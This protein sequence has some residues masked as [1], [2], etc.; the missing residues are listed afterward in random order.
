M[1]PRTACL[2]G[3]LVVLAAGRDAAAAPQVHEITAKG[4][5]AVEVSSVVA[6]VV[7]KKGA[8]GKVRVTAELTGGIMGKAEAEVHFGGGVLSIDGLDPTVNGAVTVEVP[9]GSSLEAESVDGDLTALGLAKV[10]LESVSGAVRVEGATR[11]EAQTV[12]GSLDVVGG[13]WLEL[14][15]VSGAIT[16]AMTGAAPNVEAHSVSGNIRLRGACGKGCRLELETLSGA[17]TLALDKKSSFTLQ[18]ET[19][20]GRLDDKL[21]VARSERDSG[22]KEVQARF[23]KGDGTIDA[24]TFS[25]S[26]TLTTLAA[27]AATAAPKA[28]A[29]PRSPAAPKAPPPPRPPARTGSPTPPTPPTPPAR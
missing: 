5:V 10:E 27:A 21:G 6:D 16:V 8:A 22:D 17:A 12:S 1:K 26:V 3:S 28:P 23:G 20:S 13:A 24:E 19:F 7:V 4:P 9:A 2:L 15:T 25:G 18:F 14:E 29:A 11:V